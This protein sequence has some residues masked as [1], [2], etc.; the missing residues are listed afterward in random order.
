MFK[1]LYMHSKLNQILSTLLLI[2]SLSACHTSVDTVTL[3]GYTMGTSYS[4]KVVDNEKLPN[5]VH[6][7]EEIDSALELINDQM[8]TYR[9]DSELSQFNL[10]KV[11]EAVTI[12]GDTAKVIRTGIELHS[13]TSGALDITLGPLVNIWGFG[14]DKQPTLQPS[15]QKI[16]AALALTGVEYISLSDSQIS[17]TTPSLYLDLSSIAKGFAVDKVAEIL[18]QY[19]VSGYLIE[20]GGEVKVYGE[21]TDGSRWRIAIEKPELEQRTIQQIIEP[22]DMAMATSGDYR[23]YYE[24]EGKRLS[25]LIDPRTGYPI[26]HKL[27][28][29]TVLHPSSMIADGYATAMMVLGTEDSIELAEKEQLAIMLIEKEADDFVVYYSSAFTSYI[30]N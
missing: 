9:K 1:R 15:Q 23:N 3:V 17:K 6:L 8:S 5:E 11:G 25:H 30:V 18:N 7:Q 19:A 12:S 29:V 21:K 14:P 13:V 27:V 16:D 24:L 28:S 4:I 10:A 2:F 26:E 20:I 22:V